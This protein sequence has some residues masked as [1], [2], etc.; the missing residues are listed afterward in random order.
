[1][2]LTTTC[3]A[4]DPSNPDRIFAPAAGGWLA[5]FAA[6]LNG[7]PAVV[8]GGVVAGSLACPALALA[9]DQGVHHPAV[10]R[11]TARIRRPVPVAIG[12]H[13]VAAPGGDGVIDVTIRRGEEALVVGAVQVA[14]AGRGSTP[15]QMLQPVPH[16][17]AGELD[18]MART[19]LGEPGPLAVPDEDHPFP[20]CFSCGP[21]N[22]RGLR[23]FPHTTATPAVRSSWQPA[24]ALVEANGALPTA[25]VG[26][27][28]DCS[29]A[30]ALSVA[31]EQMD[32]MRALEPI[33]AAYDMRILRMPPADQPGGYRVVARATGEDGRRYFS[34]SAMFDA[35]GAP[36]AVAETTWVL[37]PKGSFA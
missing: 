12:L 26:A 16:H 1:M 8:N 6:H 37:L 10:I 31:H 27:A 2:P 7:P 36:Y 15:G 11:V 14:D 35:D 22:S 4:C 23:I 21:A 32:G 3:H 33:L 19:S 25:I 18:A 28:L 24:A 34:M 17:L 9:H 13:A 20:D 5:S 29:N 30:M